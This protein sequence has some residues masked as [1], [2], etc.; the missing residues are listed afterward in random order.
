MTSKNTDPS[1]YISSIKSIIDGSYF[2]AGFTF[3]VIALLLTQL[4]DP[5]SMF[6]Q[7]VLLLLNILQDLS[8]FLSAWYTIHLA[9]LFAYSPHVTRGMNAA[10]FLTFI[11]A[12]LATLITTLLFYLFGLASLGLASLI[13]WLVLD[14]SAYMFIM[15]PA[16]KFDSEM[17]KREQQASKPV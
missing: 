2:V 6:S 4:K 3:T 16:Q 7:V 8:I 9:A 10:T 17:K 12:M 14:V 15:K 11:T 1:G 5:T 13:A